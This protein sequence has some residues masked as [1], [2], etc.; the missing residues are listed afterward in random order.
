MLTHGVFFSETKPVQRH[1]CHMEEVCFY[2]CLPAK[3][4]ALHVLESSALFCSDPA[5]L[6][7]SLILVSILLGIL[8]AY[9]LTSQRQ[10]FP[11]SALLPVP[12]L[13]LS[14][15]LEPP[16]PTQALSSACQFPASPESIPLSP[17]S[18]LPRLLLSLG[19]PGQALPCSPS[20]RRRTYSQTA[21]WPRFCQFAFRSIS[22]SR[23][24][25]LTQQ[26]L[27]SVP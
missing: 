19:E 4:A 5:L 22:S 12:P 14:R 16:P 9:I 21:P 24:W 26:T 2:F 27:A 17:A 18:P 23:T 11:E 15:P 20:D 10:P 3:L 1:T 25:V 8:Q 7:V 13:R 6:P